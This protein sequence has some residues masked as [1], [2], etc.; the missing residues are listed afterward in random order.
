MRK[1]L[2]AIAMGIAAVFS[3]PAAQ[4]VAEPWELAGGKKPRKPVY[5]KHVKKKSGKV[6]RISAHAQKMKA[7]GQRAAAK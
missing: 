2:A 4:S 7:A 6:K 1:S 5:P 3:G